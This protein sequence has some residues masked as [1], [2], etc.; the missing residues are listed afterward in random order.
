[1]TIARTA[2]MSG[3]GVDSYYHGVEFYYRYIKAA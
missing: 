1:M 2:R 3:V